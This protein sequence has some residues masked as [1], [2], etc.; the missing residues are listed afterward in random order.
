MRII[1]FGFA[2]F[3]LATGS[4][5]AVLGH[6][7]IGIAHAGL[8]KKTE[9]FV[10][11]TNTVPAGPN[12]EVGFSPGNGAENVILR[13]INSATTEIR[14]AAYS[15]TSRPIADALVKAARRGVDVRVLVDKS[16]RTERYTAANF[17]ANQGVSVRVDASHS[18]FHSKF[19][20]I[21]QRHTQT[22]SFNYS[23]AAATKNQENALVIWNN[24]DLA[25]SYLDN[26][27]L[28]WA[29]AEA[30]APRY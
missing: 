14:V 18:I 21:D 7:A 2:A 10:C 8:V 13:A 5:E 6:A 19:A 16:Q 9:R 28:H 27:A 22:G 24:P 4:A 30:M 12:I 17:L 29:H 23:D 25:R 20:V 3:L 15:F 26:W 1:T 11:E